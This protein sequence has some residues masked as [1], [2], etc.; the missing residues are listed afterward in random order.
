MSAVSGSL[1]KGNKENI[2]K[3]RSCCT[4][5]LCNVRRTQTSRCGVYRWICIV[6]GD[7]FL[8][9][10]GK[11]VSS[12]QVYSSLLL[13]KIK[14]GIPVITKSQLGNRRRFSFSIL[15]HRLGAVTRRHWYG[16]SWP[17]CL[18]FQLLVSPA[19]QNAASSDILYVPTSINFVVFLA[20]E[21]GR[22]NDGV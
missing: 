1:I 14:P 7:Y 6:L 3:T 5:Y 9:K 15:H 11:E 18:K 20:N 12:M 17:T 10:S 22:N 16:L 13:M 4:S 8:P 19:H 2:F 21:A